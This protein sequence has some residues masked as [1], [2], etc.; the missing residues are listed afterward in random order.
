MEGPEVVA[1]AFGRLSGILER[2]LEGLTLEQLT[3]QPSPDSNPIGWLC[4]HLARVQDDHVSNL[5][6]C[7]QA[8]VADGWHKKFNLPA[9]PTN[10]GTGDSVERVRAFRAPDAQT[11]LDYYN[12][13]HQR[14]QEYLATLTPEEMDKPVND[15]RWTPPPSVGVR[16]ISILG[17]NTQH[18]GQVA[19]LRGYISGMG[20]RT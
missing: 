5:V 1:G 8:W 2:S 13:V 18:T 14:T 19:Y 7:E 9:D 4:W 10:F 3:I 20:W 15:D 16:L 11:L 12:A 6:G 17:D